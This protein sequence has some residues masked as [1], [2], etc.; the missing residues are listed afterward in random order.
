[1]DEI[2]HRA[3][4]L[5]AVVQAIARL[6]MK[7]TDPA[8]FVQLFEER[9]AGLAVSQDLLV[10]NDWTGVDLAALV[11]MQLGHYLG[12][13]NARISIKGPPTRINASAAQTV[14]MS[15]HEL[16]TN[17]AKYGS[18]SNPAGTVEI[19]WSIEDGP[20]GGPPRFWLTWTEHDGPP[21][22][23][24]ARQGFGH[25][26]LLQMAKRALGAD[27][28]LDFPASGLIWRLTVAAER[29]VEQETQPEAPPGEDIAGR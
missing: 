12:S 15:L 23:P 8:L 10:A 18:L 9:I 26:V 17:A 25:T 28:A 3:K 20:D 22:A 5:L 2:N 16:G 11:R 24:P 27:I 13:L 19:E 6:T 21:P 14:G 4:N 1:M 7:G 29:I